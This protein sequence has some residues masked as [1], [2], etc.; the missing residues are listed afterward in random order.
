MMANSIGYDRYM[1]ASRVYLETSFFS[2]CVTTRKGDK[3]VGWRA[4]SR[5]WW[6]SQAQ[7]FD[8]FISDEVIHELSAPGFING[9]EA[10]AMLQGLKVLPITPEVE[11]LAELLCAQR[12]MPGPALSGDALHVAVATVS[13]MDFILSWNVS[14]LANPAKRTHLAVIC[15]RAGLVPPAIVT[16][17][18]LQEIDNEQ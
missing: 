2:A 7:H 4:S 12:V 14:H 8:L 17:D 11:Q 18:M 13:G 16:P 1:A 10:L 6:Q 9:P 3:V 5:E 15:M